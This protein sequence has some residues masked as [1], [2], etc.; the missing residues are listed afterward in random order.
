MAAAAVTVVAAGRCTGVVDE[1]GC[2]YGGTMVV[3]SSLSQC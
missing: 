2:E 3:G 1:A